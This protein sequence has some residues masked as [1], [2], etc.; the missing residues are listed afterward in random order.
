MTEPGTEMLRQ[1]N[2][3]H[4]YRKIR[5]IK[6]FHN[7]K[8]FPHTRWQSPLTLYIQNQ[9]RSLWP[10]QE[11]MRLKPRLVFLETKIYH[12]QYQTWQNRSCISFQWLVSMTSAKKNLLNLHISAFIIQTL[13]LFLFCI[14][15]EG[16]CTAPGSAYEDMLLANTF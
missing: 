3:N 15:P 16:W 7:S 11:V 12:L 10:T 6:F 9:M 13:F 8:V 2:E 14:S 4:V 1:L 5:E